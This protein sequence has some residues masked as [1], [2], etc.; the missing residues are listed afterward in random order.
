[1]TRIIQNCMIIV[2][3]RLLVVQE[4]TYLTEKRK[5]L[6]GFCW[7]VRQLGILE[8]PRRSLLLFSVCVIEVAFKRLCPMVGGNPSCHLHC[9]VTLRVTAPFLCQEPKLLMLV[10]STNT[11]ICLK[12][13]CWST[14]Y[15]ANYSILTKLGCPKILSL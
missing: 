15:F 9:N 6:Y 14:I 11:S 12:Q 2:C 10:S 3:S 4:N 1:M 7:S 8:A 13:H 5:N